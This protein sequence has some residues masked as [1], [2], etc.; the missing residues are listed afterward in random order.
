MVLSLSLPLVLSALSFIFF[1]LRPCFS[2][3]SSNSLFLSFSLPLKTHVVGFN[4]HQPMTIQGEIEYLPRS[5][6]LF[7]SESDLTRLVRCP[8]LKLMFKESR[9]RECSGYRRH[10]HHFW[11]V[12]LLKANSQLRRYSHRALLA[13]SPASAPDHCCSYAFAQPT[14]LFFTLILFHPTYLLVFL[15][16][17]SLKLPSSLGLL[18]SFSSLFR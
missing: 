14:C 2:V 5:L 3:C 12:C 17:V 9:S 4:G 10:L 15:P 8:P 7:L 13:D 16:P 11:S 6:I 18:R 1:C